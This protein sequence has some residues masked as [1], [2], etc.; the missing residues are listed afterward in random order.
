MSELLLAERDGDVAVLTFN[1]PE[2]RNAMTR[3]M[4]EAF[5]TAVTE[6]ARDDS[7]RCVVLT[8]AGRAFCAGGDLGMIQDQTDA[9]RADPGAARRGIRDTMRSFYGLFLSVRAI[10]CP[11]VAA[12]NGAAVGAG[13][14]VALAC[15][16]RIASEVA[17]LG[18]NFT[19]LG[20]H[21]GMG[22]TWTLPRLVGPAHAAELLYTG[23]TLTGAEAARIGLVNRAVPAAEVL[24]AAQELARE[25]A[26]AAP[27]ANRGVKR[28]LA[29]SAGVTLDDQL[30]F[31]ADVQAETF[32]SEDA[33]EGLAAARG[34]RAP[35]FSG[36]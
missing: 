31:E 28:A 16:M 15:D 6:L 18:L 14:C 26:A 24:P 12:L 27:L 1:D 20:L 23:R 10:A 22:A 11:T 2:R 9:G 35:K 34:R 17:K 4:G 21:P 8:G 33:R 7:L 29:R 30:D 25:I 36:H 32:A 5:G 19:R 3:A 13:L